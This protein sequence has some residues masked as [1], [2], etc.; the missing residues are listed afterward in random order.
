MTTTIIVIITMAWLSASAIAAW[1]FGRFVAKS[2]AASDC[3]HDQLTL[4][5]EFFRNIHP[6][7]HTVSRTVE[8][9]TRCHSCGK[10]IPMNQTLDQSDC[11]YKRVFGIEVPHNLIC[12]QTTLTN[13]QV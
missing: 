7:G 2:D 10:L 13:E 12:H 6:D 9:A 5:A 4:D 8:L 1:L 11:P 3:L